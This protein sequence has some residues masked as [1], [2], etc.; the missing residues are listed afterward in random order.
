MFDELYTIAYIDRD[1][2]DEYVNFIKDCK[3]LELP[4]YF[5]KH[6]IL[7]KSL[8]PQYEFDPDNLISLSGANHFRAHVLL[9][10]AFGGKMHLAVLWMKHCQNGDFNINIDADEYER[11]KINRSEAMSKIMTEAWKNNDE[12]REALSER[13]LLTW[14]DEDARAKRIA[15]MKIAQNKPSTKAFTAQRFAE[16]RA[17]DEM[18]ERMLKAQRLAMQT[19]EYRDKHRQNQLKRMKDPILRAKCGWNRGTAMPMR[20]CPHCGFVGNNANFRNRHLDNC[21][22]IKN[23]RACLLRI[24][25]FSRLLDSSIITGTKTTF[26]VKDIKWLYIGQT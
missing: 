16:M 8:F 15:N 26:N 18:R 25:F 20:T 24:L 4:D 14:A 19:E 10:A 5:E 21:R 9:A 17:D 12:R 6:H 1:K 7:P 23:K 22:T 2:I 13:M 3:K 11:L